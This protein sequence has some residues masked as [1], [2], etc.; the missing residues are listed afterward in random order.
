MFLRFVRPLKM[1]HMKAR[2]GFFHAAYELRDVKN[3]DHATAER[4]EDH[5]A[6]FRTNLKIP[7]KFCRSTSKGWKEATPGLGW[8]KPDA[9][10]V[11]RHAFDLAS[12]LDDQGFPIEVLRSDRVGYVLY[13]DPHQVVAEPFAN[14]PV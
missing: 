8:F 2:A 10:D 7:N 4:L 13:E 6:W 11:L 3:L 9:Q 1:T 12:L 5:L 14:T